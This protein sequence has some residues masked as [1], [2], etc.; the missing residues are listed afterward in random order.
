MTCAGPTLSAAAVGLRPTWYR[1]T[2]GQ[3]TGAT[4]ALARGLGLQPVLW[5]AWGREWTTSDPAEVARRISA[6]LSPGAIVLLHDSD[7]HGKPGM[8]RVGVEALRLV[9]DELARRDLRAGHSG[10]DDGGPKGPSD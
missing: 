1:P 2:Y 7:A 8:W 3:A 6:G 5:S 10:D 4:L 9:A